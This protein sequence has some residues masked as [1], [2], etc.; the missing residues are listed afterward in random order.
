MDAL[1]KNSSCLILYCYTPHYLSKRKESTVYLFLVSPSY[2]HLRVHRM[3]MRIYGVTLFHQRE[4]GR[5]EGRE[6][7]REG[8]GGR[9]QARETLKVLACAR[10]ARICRPGQPARGGPLVNE[11]AKQRDRASKTATGRE[12]DRALSL[13]RYRSS[14]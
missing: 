14:T 7:G 2:I 10:T 13:S 8:G 5:E 3:C 9:E 12:N 1:S 4:R 6:T 11:R